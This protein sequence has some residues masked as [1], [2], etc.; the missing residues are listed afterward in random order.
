MR[1][2]LILVID[3]KKKREIE[4]VLGDISEKVEIG[5]LK[6]YFIGL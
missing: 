4:N 1:K 2:L 3:D 6:D 5:L